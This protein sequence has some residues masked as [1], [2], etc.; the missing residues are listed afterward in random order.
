MN[1]VIV[2]F[3]FNIVFSKEKWAYHV[4]VHKSIPHIHFWTIMHVFISDLRLSR[5]LYLSIL[6]INISRPKESGFVRKHNFLLVLVVFNFL[7][8][9]SSKF[10][11]LKTFKR[12]KS[13]SNLHFIGVKTVVFGGPYE[14]FD[15]G[16]CNSHDA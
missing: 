13:L 12:L 15:F 3:F 11:A 8:H 10:K 1:H 9:G 14:L 5:T 16:E 2:T 6:T 4:I 7:P